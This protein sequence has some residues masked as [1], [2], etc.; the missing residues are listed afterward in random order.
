MKSH[1]SSDGVNFLEIGWRATFGFAPV[2][3]I[4]QFIMNAAIHWRRRIFGQ[5]LLKMVVR[6][7]M[8]P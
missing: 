2:D 4:Q 6:A 5:N 1:F 7:L 3:E 8:R